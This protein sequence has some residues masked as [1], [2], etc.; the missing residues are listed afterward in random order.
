MSREFPGPARPLLAFGGAFSL[1]GF[2]SSPGTKPDQD[3]E[4][5]PEIDEDRHQICSFITLDL[6]SIPVLSR[7]CQRKAGRPSRMS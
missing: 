1:A 6:G 2:A 5:L 7:V 3:R 4:V